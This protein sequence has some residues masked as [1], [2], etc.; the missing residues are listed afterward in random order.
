MHLCLVIPAK[1]M[2]IIQN[3]SRVVLSLVLLN[4]L[5]GANSALAQATNSAPAT[6]RPNRPTPPTRD[7]HTPGYVDAK[8]LPDGEVP[9]V[10]VEG[11][12]II[13]PTHHP[14]PQTVANTNVPQ[15]KIFNFT[16]SSA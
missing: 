9:P 10:D 12:F 2:K 4:S 5:I 3:T 13:G 1:K 6:T 14:A 16:M 8:E 15:G 11:N 7:P